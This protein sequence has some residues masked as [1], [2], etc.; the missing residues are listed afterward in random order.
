MF[1]VGLNKPRDPIIEEDKFYPAYCITHVYK[2]KYK[3]HI[4]S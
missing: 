2:T 4:N 1:I 3:P